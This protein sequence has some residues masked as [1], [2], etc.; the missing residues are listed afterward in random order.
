M[1]I[2]ENIFEEETTGLL[3]GT[4]IHSVKKL[5]EKSLE[6]ILNQSAE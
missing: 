5:K 2:R 1:V 4:G 6:R 3:L